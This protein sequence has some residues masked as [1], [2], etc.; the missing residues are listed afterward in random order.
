MR[1]FCLFLLFSCATEEKKKLVIGEN[2]EKEF[3]Q[4]K[5]L[6]IGLSKTVFLFSNDNTRFNEGD[7]VTFF[8]QHKAVCKGLVVKIKDKKAAIHMK[9]IYS[10][11]LWS[12]LRRHLE[13]FVLKGDETRFLEDYL[14][15][16]KEGKTSGQDIE[17]TFEEED[18]FKN[19]VS[20]YQK[21][22]FF[23]TGFSVGVDF[24]RKLNDELT[25][26]PQY[27]FQVGFKYVYFKLETLF[28]LVYFSHFPVDGRSAYLIS[29]YPR[30][31]AEVQFSP[32]I[33]MAPFIGLKYPLYLNSSDPDQQSVLEKDLFKSL[34]KYKID[35]GLSLIFKLVP[36]WSLELT[37]SLRSFAH[38][39]LHI[40]I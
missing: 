28:G 33:Y 5:I 10:L 21:D 25:Y 7:F 11:T 23:Y 27:F 18:L 29:L 2:L 15:K 22:K 26:F 38:I 40:E 24:H 19:D 16:G 39:G 13:L 20:S 3:F 8:L 6:D 32:S 37:S 17:T 31:K 1:I 34:E 4:E 35:A 14:L 12:S 30:L 9:K 36:G